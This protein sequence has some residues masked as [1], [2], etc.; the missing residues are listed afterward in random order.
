MNL[1]TVW[2]YRSTHPAYPGESPFHP[3]TRYPEYEF[4]ETSTAENSAYDSVRECL[5]L[6][7][8]DPEHY[9]APSWNPL[10]DLIR[11]GETVLLKPNLVCESHPR[12][13]DGWRYVLTHG[14]VIR[15]LGDY[16]FKA[17]EGRGK[18]VLADAPQTDSSFQAIS[19]RL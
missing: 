1:Q 2:A 14:S 15:A 6:A 16:V 8:C 9:G 11:P 10:R 12:D 7:G 5:R 3:S 18:V 13:P 17:L 19:L 4:A